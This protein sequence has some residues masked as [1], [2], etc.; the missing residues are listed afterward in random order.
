MDDILLNF[1]PIETQ[2]FKYTVFIKEAGPGEER[3]ANNVWKYP[4]SFPDSAELKK[5]YW[6]SLE[7]IDGYSPCTCSLETSISFTKHFLYNHLHETINSIQSIPQFTSDDFVREVCLEHENCGIYSKVFLL[8]PY[9]LERVKK[10]GFIISYCIKFKNDNTPKDVKDFIKLQ[11]DSLSLDRNGRANRNYYL[12]HLEYIRQFVSRLLPQINKCLTIFKLSSSLQPVNSSRLEKKIYVFKDNKESYSQYKGL[13]EYG[14][15]QSPNIDTQIIFVFRNQHVEFAR[16]LYRA[17]SGNLYKTIFGGMDK[18]FGV[19][20]SRENIKH[21]VMQDFKIDIETIIQQCNHESLIVY[22]TDED[23]SDEYINLKHTCLKNNIPCQ[24]VT[25]DLIKNR[26]SLKWAVGSIAVQ[27]FA[28]MGGKPWIVKPSN[29]KC[30]IIGIGQAHQRREDGSISK[31][32]AYSVLTEASGLFK[33]INLLACSE[34]RSIYIK[35]LGDHVSSIINNHKQDYNKFVIHVPFKVKRDEIEKIKDAIKNIELPNKEI[36]VLK[37]NTDNPFMGFFHSKNC[38][39]PY[40][41]TVV[42]LSS[43]E[44]L[45]WF[46]GLQY[47]SE[48]VN[49]RI[50]GPTHLQFLY[51]YPNRFDYQKKEM[52]LQDSLNLSGANWRGF[53]AKSIPVSIHYCRLV[54]KFVKRFSECGLDIPALNTLNPWFL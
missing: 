8:R 13:N 23:D 28:K 42:Y 10:L 54:A 38:K 19:S 53:N 33:D 6:V 14:P 12:D 35:S 48:I 36:C 11:K 7:T 29:E 3:P 40:E 15:L 9:Y 30:L 43:N 16:D 18:V 26:D 20:F 39:V 52:Y 46:E 21:Y 45:M 32:Y 31:Y 2:D 47:G 49:G 34:E 41:S 4:L 50:P 1:L 5:D 51:E 37:I 17:L 27:I 44:C 25:C 22:L 24:V